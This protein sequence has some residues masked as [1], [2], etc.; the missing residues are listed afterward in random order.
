MQMR[1]LE[2]IAAELAD[3]LIQH[4]TKIYV[5]PEEIHWPDG[6]ITKPAENE[7]GKKTK[8]K[9]KSPTARDGVFGK[10]VSDYGP[11]KKS[12]S[13]STSTAVPQEPNNV[14]VVNPQNQQDD[15]SGDQASKNKKRR[16]TYSSFLTFI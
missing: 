2:I 5:D 3:R 4:G 12:G 8:K 11:K 9:K 10:I 13:T 6:T 14:I 1:I 15:G 7:S 16:K